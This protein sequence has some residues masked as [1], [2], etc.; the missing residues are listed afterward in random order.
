MADEGET[1]LDE[2]QTTPMTSN[3]GHSNGSKETNASSSAL[4]SVPS[5]FNDG[6]M[7]PPDITAEDAPISTPSQVLNGTSTHSPADGLSRGRGRGRGGRPR[8]S[9]SNG[10]TR[11]SISATPDSAPG[12]ARGSVR[13][14]WRGRGRGRGG[15]R[16][17][18]DEDEIKAEDSPSESD[19]EAS[20]ED[21]YTPQATETRSG[22]AVQKPTSFAPPPPPTPTPITGVK[23]K[24]HVHRKNPE[25]TV[26]NI[27]QR[28]HSPASNMIVFCDG[29]NTPYHRYCHH[30]P[31]EQVVV[32]VPEKEWYC[33]ECE[34][35]Y[36]VEYDVRTFTSGQGLSEEKVSG[37]HTSCL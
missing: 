28:P 9:M 22:R 1:G 21:Q 24:R 6:T 20:D 4:S 37:H 7:M 12:S 25:L 23:R 14:R 31:I 30:P 13:G 35:A 8:G 17:K 16:R 29:C 26:C 11:Q 10:T 34:A 15:K 27:C 2:A 36:T 33:A 32:D 19:P 3:G 5:G 18:V